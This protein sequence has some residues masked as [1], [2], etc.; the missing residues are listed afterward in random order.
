VKHDALKTEINT[1]TEDVRR[2]RR[3]AL[4][5]I[6]EGYRLRRGNGPGSDSDKAKGTALLCKGWL[7]IGHIDFDS[8]RRRYLSLAATLLNGTPYLKAEATRDPKRT[9]DVSH[10]RLNAFIYDFLPDD[11][12]GDELIE[13]WLAGED[14]RPILH[15]QAGGGVVTDAAE[16][17]RQE[18]AEQ[19]KARCLAEQEK[20]D[21]EMLATLK[22]KYEGA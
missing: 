4:E 12:S 8:E 11:V 3:E 2:S 10:V 19:E 15:P 5:A 14:I 22:A 16:K 13:A 1:I 9:P 17:V 7:W 6:R 18:K 20:R 21:R